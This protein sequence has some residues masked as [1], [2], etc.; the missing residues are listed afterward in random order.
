MKFRG[1]HANEYIILL[2]VIILVFLAATSLLT[3]N[4]GGEKDSLAES[5]AYWRAAAPL[6]LVAASVLDNG[7]L[8]LVVR[9]RGESV[10]LK[11]VIVGGTVYHV[12]IRIDKDASATV[13]LP[14]SLKSRSGVCSVSLRFGFY[15]AGII[16]SMQK[17]D[18]PLVVR[19]PQA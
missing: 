19:C 15:V 10:Q 3:W 13:V 1:Q 6:S 16:N 17:S 8:V 14:A 12:P 11:D 2:A 7:S 4:F 9:N 5:E 18:H